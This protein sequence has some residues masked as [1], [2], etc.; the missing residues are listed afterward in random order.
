MYTGGALF[1]RLS[2]LDLFCM[3]LNMQLTA[4]VH[5]FQGLF[6]SCYYI[7]YFNIDRGCTS[8]CQKLFHFLT[9][10]R[11]LKVGRLTVHCNMKLSVC[12]LVVVVIY[13]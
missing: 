13:I 10:S 12:C 3:L 1:Q 6:P 11:L 5:E 8:A 9:M 7:M 4:F 2:N